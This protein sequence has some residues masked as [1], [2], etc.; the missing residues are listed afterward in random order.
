VVARAAEVFVAL[1]GEGVD[2]WRPVEAEP[3]NAECFRIASANP[4]FT[5]PKRRSR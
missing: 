1:I 5:N 3:V 4:Q 2:V